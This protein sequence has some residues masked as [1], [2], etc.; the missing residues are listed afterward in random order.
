[1]VLGH[2]QHLA[3]ILLRLD[4]VAGAGPRPCRVAERG[5][6]DAAVEP[7]AYLAGMFGEIR[8][9]RPQGGVRGDEVVATEQHETLLELRACLQR[10]IADPSGDPQ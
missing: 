10:P 9:H 1:M 2:C 4:Q 5:D 8:T 7:V 3:D 6:V